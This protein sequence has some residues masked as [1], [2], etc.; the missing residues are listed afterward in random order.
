MHYLFYKIRKDDLYMI[1]F[2]LESY[3]NIAQ[4]STIDRNI[5]KIQITIAPDFLQDIE[6]I[7]EDL[8]TRFYME[9]IFD[10]PTVSQGN[11]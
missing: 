4:V 6:M 10:D 9:Q 11:Y 8:K 2:L 7:I 1:K 5:T 3:E